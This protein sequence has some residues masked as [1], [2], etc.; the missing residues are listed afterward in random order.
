MRQTAMRRDAPGTALASLPIVTSAHHIR[1]HRVAI[2]ALAV[3][4]VTTPA[5][6]AVNPVDA[7]VH[8]FARTHPGI[9]ALV[10]R[11]DASGPVAVAAVNA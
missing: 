8:A 4:T 11:L 6:A 3:L 10:T 9:S 7:T 2:L 1:P 5:F